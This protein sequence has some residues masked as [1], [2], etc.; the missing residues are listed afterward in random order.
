MN[1]AL[2]GPAWQGALTTVFKGAHDA[3]GNLGPAM[4]ALGDAF[5]NLAPVLARIMDLATQIATVAIVGIAEALQDPVFT[6]GLGSMLEGA[7]AGMQAFAPAFTEIAK[8][9]GSILE[10]A[11]VM[12]EAFG[13][14]LA[15]ALIAFAP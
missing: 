11:G 1:T 3:M 15:E 4:Q 13:P 7:L 6:S 10:L 14:L 9:M 5:I 8:H 2:S 12:A